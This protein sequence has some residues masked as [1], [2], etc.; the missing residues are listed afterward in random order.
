[1]P[2]SSTVDMNIE[3]Y[4]HGIT[5]SHKPYSSIYKKDTFVTVKVSNIV[6]YGV[7]FEIQDEYKGIG[8]LYIGKIQDM[9]IESLHEFFKI[10]DIIE[11]VK[12][13]EVT[14][15][16][17]SFSTLHLDLEKKHKNI[18]NSKDSIMDIKE[19]IAKKVGILSREAEEKIELIIQERGIVPFVI[20]MTKVLDDYKVDVSLMLVDKIEEKVGECL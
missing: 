7:F 17:L 1:M 3:K 12:I 16:K 8:L 15:D 11:N 20:A 13:I 14:S 4:I 2:N 18:F 10:G 9:F 19:R 6:P 5:L